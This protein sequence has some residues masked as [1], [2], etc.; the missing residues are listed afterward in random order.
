KPRLELVPPV[1]RERE[2]VRDLVRPEVVALQR[3]HLVRSDE[4][5]PE[6]AF[7]DALFGE[8]PPRERDRRFL[9]DLD[10][11]AVCHLD[12]DHRYRRRCVPVSSAWSLYASTI[13]CT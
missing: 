12:R 8:D 6:L 10:A 5:Q 7:L 11:A 4:V 1:D 9:L 13:R 2:D 3:P